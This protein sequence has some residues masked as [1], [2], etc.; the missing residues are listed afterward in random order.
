MDL[1]YMNSSLFSVNFHGFVVLSLRILVLL[2][3]VSLQ[4]L[5]ECNDV[6][7]PSMIIVGSHIWTFFIIPSLQERCKPLMLG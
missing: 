4:G 1:K 3:R 5:D 6:I 2:S 7:G